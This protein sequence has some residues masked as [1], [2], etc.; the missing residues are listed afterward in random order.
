MQN[1]DDREKAQQIIK[2]ARTTRLVGIKTIL[3]DKT[4]YVT[5]L[6]YEILNPSFGGGMG[7]GGTRPRSNNNG[8]DNFSGGGNNN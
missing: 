6:E 3:K 1:R 4:Q 7:M 8:G 2:L 5:Y